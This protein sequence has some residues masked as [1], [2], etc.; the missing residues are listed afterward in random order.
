MIKF[1]L[2]EA[3][4]DLSAAFAFLLLLLSLTALLCSIP[5][6]YP[7]VAYA[8]AVST[9]SALLARVHLRHDVPLA[10]YSVAN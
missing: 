7:L 10:I 1:R 9:S 3:W 5:A 8:A 6:E 4:T 2:S